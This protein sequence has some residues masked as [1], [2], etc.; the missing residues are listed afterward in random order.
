MNDTRRDFLKKTAVTAVG[1]SMGAGVYA[2]DFNKGVSSGATTFS[3]PTSSFPKFTQRHSLAL[4]GIWDF[5]WLGDIDPASFSPEKSLN[6]DET[7]AVPGCFN[8]AGSRIGTRG[9]GLYRTTFAFPIVHS[10]LTFGGLGLYARVWL[11]GVNIAE[12][13]N[14]YATLAFDIDVK[15]TTG[16]RHE[17]LVLVDNRFDIERVPVFNPWNDFYGYGGI[18]RGIKI[19]QLPAT[20]VE[21]VKV[22]TIDHTTGRVRL[23]A[24]LGGK[25]PARL[26]VT[27]AFDN[28]AAKETT[29]EIAPGKNNFALE[30]QVPAHSIW[31]PETP[32]LH[33]L[34]LSISPASS[35]TMFTADTVVE[36]FGVRTIATQGRNILLNGKPVQLRGVNRHESHPQFGPIQPTQII[37]NDLSWLRELNANFI[38]AVHYQPGAEFLDACDRDGILVWAESLGW[39]QP[40][41]DS[42]NPDV[43]ALH[44]EAASALVDVCLNHPSVIIYGF[45]NESRSDTETG[46]ILYEAIAKTIC[47]ADSSRL[48]SYASNRIERDICFDLADVISINTYPGWIG[49][50]SGLEMYDQWT[51]PGV[52]RIRGEIER[53]AHI[54]TDVPEYSD[55]PLLMSEIGTCGM[56]G[57]HDRARAQWS[58]EFQS[59][60]V[61]EAV[62][63]ILSHPRYAGVALWQM[64][65]TQS[66][67]KDGPGLRTKP[68]GMNLAGLLDE[69]RRPKLAFDTVKAIFAKHAVNMK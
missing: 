25:I 59:D 6:F 16:G 29:M 41:S 65:D 45:L 5:R 68:R 12:I 34:T 64:F 22:T 39:G 30:T 4:D 23:E 38:R 36:C 1:I 67:S 40:E 55:K 17:L 47:D 46:R 53:V 56:F 61:R 44:C 33:T 42:T 57:V 62:E 52:S 54:F 49:S 7:A 14:P 31:S 9:A 18:Y 19:S 37:T 51:T 50:F 13:K 21:R 58:E 10:R 69:Y 48:I 3:S 24:R 20:R 43:L 35:S 2:I 28:N 11:D 66:Y 63:S 27:Y 60:Y 8:L 15:A 26:R 32:A